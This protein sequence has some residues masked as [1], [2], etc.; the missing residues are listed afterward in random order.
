ML[1]SIHHRCVPAELIKKIILKSILIRFLPA[2]PFE[3]ARM[4]WLWDIS[5]GKCTCSDTAIH[6]FMV[7]AHGN[8]SV[9]SPE[10]PYEIQVNMTQTRYRPY[11]YILLKD[12]DQ[13][14]F[15][16]RILYSHLVRDNSLV[17]RLTTKDHD[18]TEPC[19]LSSV[20]GSD[21]DIYTCGKP[22]HLVKRKL[23]DKLQEP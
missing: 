15:V 17:T 6:F 23:M 11:C 8:R 16:T 9:L 3:K 10:H 14:D 12:A 18:D 22:V 20:H 19:S 4:S 2:D 5:V 7:D 1:Y 21:I 13:M